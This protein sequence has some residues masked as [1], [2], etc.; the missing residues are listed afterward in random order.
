MSGSLDN[1]AYLDPGTGALLMQVIVGAV[2]GALYFMRSTISGLWLTITGGRTAS[3]QPEALES[4]APA[5]DPSGAESADKAKT[6]EGAAG[7]D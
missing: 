4:D 6:D 2:A 5:A 7:G 3:A 1:L